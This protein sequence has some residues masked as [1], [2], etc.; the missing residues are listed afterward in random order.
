MSSKIE[1]REDPTAAAALNKLSDAIARDL[2]KAAKAFSAADVDSQG[3]LEQSGLLR[4]VRATWNRAVSS[5]GSGEAMRQSGWHRDSPIYDLRIAPHSPSLFRRQRSGRCS[6]PSPP[7]S[8]SLPLPP[9][10]RF[11]RLM[12]PTFKA[13]EV[14]AVLTYL[15]LIDLNGDGMFEFQEIVCVSVNLL[16]NCASCDLC[17]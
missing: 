8:P 14:R 6:P 15:H 9:P 11:I 7:P 4:W 17:F 2:R 1:T 3:Y 13:P 10:S 5:G 16:L 12:V